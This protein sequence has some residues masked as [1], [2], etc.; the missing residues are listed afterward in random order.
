M[1]ILKLKQMPLFEI[2]QYFD[3]FLE[4]G[5][6][7]KMLMIR[8]EVTYR[9]KN[10]MICKD[11]LVEYEQVMYSRQINS[12]GKEF[13]FSKDNVSRYLKSIENVEIKYRF[14]E[15]EKR[16]EEILNDIRE[17]SSILDRR[18]IFSNFSY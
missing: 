9:Y 4:I 18:E 17:R 10:K 5:D 14:S 16:Q 15:K 8:D 1:L 3:S 6:Y 11:D 13:D 2:R 12:E 7:G